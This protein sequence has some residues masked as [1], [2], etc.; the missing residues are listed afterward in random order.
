M[1]AASRYCSGQWE[2]RLLTICNDNTNHVRGHCLEIHDLMIAKLV[3]GRQKDHEF[4][5]AAIQLKL[6]SQS[7]LLERLSDTPLP[8]DHREKLK[9]TI[10]REFQHE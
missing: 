2:T 4:F 5:E 8:D 7:A 6:V 9:Y 3:A 10:L 1:K